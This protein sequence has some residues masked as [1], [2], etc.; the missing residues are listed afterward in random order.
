MKL[1]D[2]KGL[3]YFLVYGLIIV[4]AFAYSGV[5]GWRWFHSTRTEKQAGQR[6]HRG[7]NYFYRYH[8]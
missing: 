3:K 1:E 4:C 6:V 5:N 2:L 7:P 8:K